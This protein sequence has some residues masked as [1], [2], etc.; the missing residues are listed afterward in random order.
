MK[1]WISCDKG[2]AGVGYYVSGRFEAVSLAQ[3][4]FSKRFYDSV[5]VAHETK[6]GDLVIWKDGQYI[7]S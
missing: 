1:Y 3:K 6:F 5:F 4:I 2:S 7:F